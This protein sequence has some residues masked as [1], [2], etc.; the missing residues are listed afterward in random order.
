MLLLVPLPVGCRSVTLLMNLI[1]KCIL[2]SLI[3]TG[4]LSGQIDQGIE[5][6]VLGAQ[7]QP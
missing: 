1:R 2:N 4:K 7:Q 5:K 6:A 3:L